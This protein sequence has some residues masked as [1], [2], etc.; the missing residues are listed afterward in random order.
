VP[1]KMWQVKADSV[2][3]LN[4]RHSPDCLNSPR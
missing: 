2:C 3:T 4:R 1:L